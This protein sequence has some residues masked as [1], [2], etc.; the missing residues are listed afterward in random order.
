MK[1][2]A[3]RLGAAILTLFFQNGQGVAAGTAGVDHQGQPQLLGGM[4]VVAKT[5]TLPCHVGDCSVAQAVI[6]QAGFANAHHLGV[7]TDAQQIVQAGFLH[8][9]FIGMHTGSA[10]K[11]VMRHGQSMYSGEGFQLGAD[12]QGTRDLRIRHVLANLAQV[13]LQLREVQVAMGI[14]VHRLCWANKCRGSSG[15]RAIRRGR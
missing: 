7:V 15:W 11:I 5:L 10:P 2:A 9:V 4:D 8:I 1:H 13:G 14:G 6:V 3:H 12:Q